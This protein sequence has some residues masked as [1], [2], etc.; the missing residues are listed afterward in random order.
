[1]GIK[2]ILKLEMGWHMN[3]YN[4]RE[5]YSVRQAKAFLGK[6]I[7]TMDRQFAWSAMV[8]EATRSPLQANSVVVETFVNL[9][10][11]QPTLLDIDI[12]T[13]NFINEL[14]IPDSLDGDTFHLPFTQLKISTPKGGIDVLWGEDLQT[15]AQDIIRE[16]AGPDYKFNANTESTTCLYVAI[17]ADTKADEMVARYTSKEITQLLK[18]ESVK[19]I[20]DYHF[21]MNGGASQTE[22]QTLKAAIVFVFK[23]SMLVSWKGLDNLFAISVRKIKYFPNCN[24]VYRF[25]PSI[26]PPKEKSAYYVAPF[27][28]QLRDPKYYQDDFESWPNGTRFTMVSGHERTKNKQA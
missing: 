1:V 11:M 28:R 14:N 9:D 5:P 25:K 19:T 23:L 21:W 26:L 13:F 2:K 12:D 24:K 10:Q 22:T 6:N 7:T 8:S 15:M 18:N 4:F 20:K 17:N 16:T 27:M 3:R